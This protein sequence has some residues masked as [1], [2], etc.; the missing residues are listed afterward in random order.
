MTLQLTRRQLLQQLGATAGAAMVPLGVIRGQ[1]AP[2]MV[3]G[4]PVEIAVFSVSPDTVRI[5]V[6]PIEAGTPRLFPTR[7]RLW[8]MSSVRLWD[9]AAQ[10]RVSRVCAPE[11]SRW[12]SLT[13]RRRSRSAE[14][15]R[16]FKRCA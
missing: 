5:T 8:P 13:G 9:A 15:P 6:R 16:P 14:A 4:K 2:I 11:D 7:A 3:A 12:S 1:E 10:Q